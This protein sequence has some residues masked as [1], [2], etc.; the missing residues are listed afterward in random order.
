M[1]LSKLIQDCIEVFRKSTD[2][3][4][5]HDSIIKLGILQGSC[6]HLLE[7]TGYFSCYHLKGDY[8]YVNNKDEAMQVLHNLAVYIDEDAI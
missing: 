1:K 2:R 5:D 3:Y 7:H 6:S 8:M 4:L